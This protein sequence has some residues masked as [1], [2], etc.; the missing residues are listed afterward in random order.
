M[1]AVWCG[2]SGVRSQVQGVRLLSVQVVHSHHPLGYHCDLTVTF[3][4]GVPTA[5]PWAVSH[6]DLTCVDL[7]A[8]VFLNVHGGVRV[9]PPG[10]L[11]HAQWGHVV[12]VSHSVCFMESCRST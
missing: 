12:F 9:L 5:F 11:V 10:Q 8:G 4:W 2:G 3:P 6:F 1:V 7:G